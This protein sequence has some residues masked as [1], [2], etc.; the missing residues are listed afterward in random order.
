MSDPLDT[1]NVIWT[2]PSVNHLGS[3]PIGNGDIG[4]NLWVEAGGALVFYT[5]PQNH[6]LYVVVTT[7]VVQRASTTTEV[8]TTVP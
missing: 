3:M 5:P 6:C 1:Y 7:S 4:L 8:V 2:S